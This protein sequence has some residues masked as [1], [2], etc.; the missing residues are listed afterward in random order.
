MS[1]STKTD[2]R[3]KD[4]LILG[5]GPTQGLKS[6][7]SAE[8]MYSINF[9]K[10]NK[11]F[12]LRSHYNGANSYLFV[13]GTEIIKFKAKDWK[14]LAYSLCLWNISKDWTNDDMKKKGFNGYIYDLST[15]YNDIA[16]WDIL[17][18]HKY[19]MKKNGIVLKMFRFIKQIL[20]S[21][22]MLFSSLP[23]VNS[24]KCVSLKNQECK[25]RPV[26]V[27]I[28]SNNPIL[29]PFSVKINKCSGNCNNINDP[30]AKIWAVDTVKNLNVKVLNLMSRTNETRFI[31]WHE[32]CKCICRLDKVI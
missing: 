17:G 31:K 23:N 8:K 19:L 15:D 2:N 14:Y 30:Y 18:I 16:V 21:A 27:D 26:I 9:T 1:S 10:K 28:N 5:K 32:T 4:I 13:N 11:K 6:T 3:K 7:R 12:C 29:Y 22:M 25:V 24:L 20:I